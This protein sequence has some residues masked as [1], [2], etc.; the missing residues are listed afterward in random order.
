[1]TSAVGA[2]HV[3]GLPRPAKRREGAGEVAGGGGE[4]G[5]ESVGLLEMGEGGA[6]VPAP[7]VKDPEVLFDAGVIRVEA[8]RLAVLGL[9]L[10]KPPG[11]GQSVAQGIAGRRVFG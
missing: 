10:V 5:V 7:L 3:Q 9:R 4:I 2:D 8:Q 1:M 11:T 6:E